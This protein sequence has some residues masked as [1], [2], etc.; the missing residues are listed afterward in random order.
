M[1]F[2]VDENLHDDVAAAFRAA[3]HD[4]RTVFEQGLRG[5]SDQDLAWVCRQEQRAIVTLDLDFANIRTYPPEN[6][7]GLIVLR[8][9]SQ[10][11]PHVLEV[12]SPILK[13]LKREPLSGHL[14]IVSEA[15]VRVRS[16]A[17]PEERP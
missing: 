3:G 5:Q 17:S 15:G 8:V 9:V 14:W 1:R 6:F 10:S 4:A 7:S 2:K 13:L 12:L 16:G 11:R